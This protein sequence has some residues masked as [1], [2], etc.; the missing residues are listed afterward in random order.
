M[1]LVGFLIR[2]LEICGV[3]AK[4]TNSNT[5]IGYGTGFSHLTG[6]ENTYIGKYAGFSDSTGFSNTFIGFQSGYI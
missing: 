4:S 3:Y 6:N 1:I 2:L 5:F